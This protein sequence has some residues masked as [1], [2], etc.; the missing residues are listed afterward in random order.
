MKGPTSIL[1]KKTFFTF[2][3]FYYSHTAREVFIARKLVA[4]LLK[5]Q[6]G[7]RGEPTTIMSIIAL[8]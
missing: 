2:H 4:R 7:E 3:L 8:S 1:Y 5:V 6:H